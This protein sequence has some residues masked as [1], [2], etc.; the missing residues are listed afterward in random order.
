[1]SKRLVCSRRHPDK[2]SKLSTLRRRSSSWSSSRK[3]SSQQ[4]FFFTKAQRS[5]YINNTAR[6][7]SETP[8]K[9][10][11]NL[12]GEAVVVVAAIVAEVIVME[13]LCSPRRPGEGC[14]VGPVFV[15]VRCFLHPHAP[16]K[17]FCRSCG[18]YF[19]QSASICTGICK[20]PRQEQCT[21]YG[22]TEMSRQLFAAARTIALS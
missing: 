10:L 4:S 22:L 2:G 16:A 8:W 1:M 14:L 6:L 3:L 18:A 17:M 19:S 21:D 20:F 11:K 5:S 9:S 7:I 12:N 13:V 15:V